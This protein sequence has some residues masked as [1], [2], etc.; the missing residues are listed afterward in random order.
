MLICLLF[1]I[2]VIFCPQILKFIIKQF[3]KDKPANSSVNRV[4]FAPSIDLIKAFF[5]D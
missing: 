3:H 5:A 1:I 2:P 4:N